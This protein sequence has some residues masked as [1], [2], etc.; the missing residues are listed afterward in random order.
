MNLGFR[1]FAC[2]LGVAALVVLGLGASPPPTPPTPPSAA[3]W[4]KI[5]AGTADTDTVFY[6][7]DSVRI[8]KNLRY[9]WFKVIFAKKH[10]FDEVKGYVWSMLSYEAMDCPSRTSATVLEIYYDQDGR[11]LGSVPSSHLTFEPLAPDSMGWL[12]ANKVCGLG[13]GRE[14][15][16]HGKGGQIGAEN[17]LTMGSGFVVSPN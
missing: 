8:E 3:N 14:K 9:V 15:A 2:S 12:A 1:A 17:A 11:T 10:Y 7:A 16:P 13:A 6:D 5:A 4:I